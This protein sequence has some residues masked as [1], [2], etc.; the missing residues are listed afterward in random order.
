[1][2]GT[3]RTTVGSGVYNLSLSESGRNLSRKMSLLK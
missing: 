1:M 3:R 2:A